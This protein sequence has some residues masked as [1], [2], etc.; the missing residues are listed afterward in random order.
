MCVPSL[1]HLPLG[2][3]QSWPGPRT[4]KVRLGRRAGPHQPDVDPAGPICARLLLPQH[5]LVSPTHTPTA[6]PGSVH[7]NAP[8]EQENVFKVCLYIII[9]LNDFLK[10]LLFMYIIILF[11][12]FIFILFYL[13]HVH[14]KIAVFVILTGILKLMAL[15]GT[16][17]PAAKAVRCLV[18]QKALLPLVSARGTMP[19]V[20]H[21]FSLSLKYWHREANTPTSRWTPTGWDLELQAVLTLIK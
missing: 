6:Q 7:Q 1:T 4:W 16:N 12:H 8:V 11:F 19:S 17:R 10:Y 9:N 3:S 14:K 21:C 2:S 5:S 15:A 20:R 18:R 13:V